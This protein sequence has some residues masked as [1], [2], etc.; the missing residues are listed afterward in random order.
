MKKEYLGLSRDRRTN[1]WRLT[2]SKCGKKWRPLTTM[3][4]VKV[5]T[6]PKCEHEEVVDYNA[7]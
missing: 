6:C 7:D 2:C 4:A 5:E 1:R 3:F